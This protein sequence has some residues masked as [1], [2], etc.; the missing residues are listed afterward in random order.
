MITS[1]MI[2]YGAI[3]NYQN[4]VDD[5]IDI[6][7]KITEEALKHNGNITLHHKDLIFQGIDE[8]DK[9][10]LT[11]VDQGNTLKY[12]FVNLYS[13]GVIQG[14]IFLYKKGVYTPEPLEFVIDWLGLR[15]NGGNVT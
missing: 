8:L 10:I 11:E 2:T 14:R 7:D 5:L 9:R 3:D 4:F 13:L 6:K 12:S 15:F 1:Y